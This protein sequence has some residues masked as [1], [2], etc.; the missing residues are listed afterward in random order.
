MG[1]SIMGEGT[2]A[3]SAV[4]AAGMIP[5]IDLVVVD[6][7][8]AEY[9]QNVA[10]TLAMLPQ[11]TVTPVLLLSGG[12]EAQILREATE[13]QDMVA[14]GDSAISDIALAAVLEGLLS[15]AAGGS[16]D[17]DEAEVFAARA[18]AVLRD[19]ALAD[20]VLEVE[21]ATGALI[22]AL[23]IANPSTQSLVAETLSMVDSP[24][25]QQALVSAALQEGR[26]ED[27]MMFLDE[28][29]ASV[30]RW[31]NLSKDWQV[32]EIETLAKTTSGDLADAAARLNGAMNNP[33]A[34]VMIFMP[35]QN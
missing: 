7:S 31:G 24:E 3:Q 35:E 29:S 15:K 16:L 22:D 2:T 30:R 21:D 11:T 19:I 8:S 27:R 23:T 6:A 14:A 13:T 32:V 12:V 18:L 10:G 28:A 33:G 1:W 17:F 20:T 26:I 34:S 9:A 25:A 5:G 4:E